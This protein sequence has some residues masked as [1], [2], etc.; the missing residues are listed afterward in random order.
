MHRVLP[1]CEPLVAEAAGPATCCESVSRSRSEDE[2]INDRPDAEFLIPPDALRVLISSDSDRDLYLGR[3][4][5]SPS[6][7]RIL[8]KKLLYC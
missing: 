1:A 3:S 2:I 4:F 8:N 5:A 6:T 7:G